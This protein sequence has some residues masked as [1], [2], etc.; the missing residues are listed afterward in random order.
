MADLE[1]SKAEGDWT[2]AS[3]YKAMLKLLDRVPDLEAIFISND[4]MALGALQAAAST[5]RSVPGDLAIVGFDDI[6]EAAYFSPSLST[7]RQDL[8]ELGCQA[9][10][11]LNQ[12]LEAQRNEEPLSVQAAKLE[13]SLIVRQSSLRQ[14]S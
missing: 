1:R 8:L 5:G 7:V 6:P 9:V 14:T 4:S 10:S 3:G 13:P 11:M 12:Q 2:A